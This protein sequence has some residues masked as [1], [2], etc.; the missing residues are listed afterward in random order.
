MRRCRRCSCG[1][2]RGGGRGQPRCHAWRA[3]VANTRHPLSPRTGFPAPHT[4]AGRKAAPLGPSSTAAAASTTTAPAGSSSSSTSAG[5]AGGGAGAPGDCGSGA[6]VGAG[7]GAG[8]S[9]PPGSALT[10]T[11]AAAAG[12]CSSGASAPASRRASLPLPAFRARADWGG[13]GAGARGRP[14][15]ATAPPDTALPL[16]PSRRGRLW[17]PRASDTSSSSSSLQIMAANGSIAPASR[18]PRIRARA[19]SPTFS[20]RVRGRGRVPRTYRGRGAAGTRGEELA[21]PQPRAAV[22][23]RALGRSG[24]AA[25]VAHTAFTAAPRLGAFRANRQYP[26]GQNSS[27]ALRRAPHRGARTASAGLRRRRRV[28]RRGD[29]GSM[30]H[31]RGMW[32][33][34]PSRDPL[35]RS[36]S[37]D[38]DAV[39]RPKLDALRCGREHA[40]AARAH[41]ADS[42][43]AAQARELRQLRH[44]DPGA[45]EEGRGRHGGEG[46]WRGLRDDAPLRSWRTALERRGR[47]AP[48]GPTPNPPCAMP[49]APGGRT[50]RLQPAASYSRPWT[51]REY[52]G[53]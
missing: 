52:S 34:R 43:S 31:G 47:P 14:G 11:A 3:C 25:A 10:R 46:S 18:G 2:Q 38:G 23:A 50:R 28:A 30:G 26:G 27:A 40:L 29:T 4:C 20:G 7:A 17:S 15:A 44:R 35:A 41:D 1:T 21:T 45:C 48:A 53:S 42:G 5:D 49:N 16:P 19:P 51:R 22:Q 24:G 36:G 13:A 6:G 37:D 8:S 12:G 33:C 39:A 32:A 9:A